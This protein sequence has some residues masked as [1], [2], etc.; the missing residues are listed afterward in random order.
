ME[1]NFSFK[2]IGILHT[3]FKTKEGIPIQGVFD[4]DARGRAEVFKEYEP[5]LQDIEGFSHLILIYVFHRS[6]GYDLVCR[7]YM[8]DQVR[9]LFAIRAPR[10]PNPIGFSVV[11]QERREGNVLYLAEMDVMDGTPLLDIKPFVPRFDHREGARVGWMEE[12]FKKGHLRKVSDD[13]F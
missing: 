9:G 7:P 6:T 13:R 8:E 12:R 4:P 10:R 5:G 3:P 2:S 1:Q 11:R